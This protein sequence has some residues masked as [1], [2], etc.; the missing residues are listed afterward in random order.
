MLSTLHSGKTSLHLPSYHICISSVAPRVWSRAFQLECLCAVMAS[1]TPVRADQTG[2]VKF[3]R[4]S[5]TYEAGLVKRSFERLSNSICRVIIKVE[6]SRP[7]MFDL[8]PIWIIFH[9]PPPLEV[10]LRINQF[11]CGGFIY[12]TACGPIS[13]LDA[14]ESFGLAVIFE[15]TILLVSSYQECLYSGFDSRTFLSELFYRSLER[16]FLSLIINHS[17]WLSH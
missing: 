3:V 15:G 4:M 5:S 14:N 11:F 10:S 16:H 13:A 9:S 6:I 2:G 17:M 12:W 7:G 1:S 8:R